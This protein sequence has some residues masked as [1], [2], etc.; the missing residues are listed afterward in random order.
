MLD[1]SKSPYVAAF[2]AYRMVTREDLTKREPEA[3]VRIHVFDYQRWKTNF[4]QFPQMLFPAL[5]IS[6]L[7]FVPVENERLIPQQ[8]VSTITNVD[9]I[10][11]YIRARE[12]ESKTPT[13]RLAICL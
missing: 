6:V 3:K 10:E 2:F 13:F 9:D 7:E 1:W 8:S 5:H 11:T 12:A 4:P